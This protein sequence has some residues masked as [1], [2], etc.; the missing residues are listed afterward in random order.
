MFEPLRTLI[1]IFWEF[2]FLDYDYVKSLKNKFI[3]N[4]N[5]V[6]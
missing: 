4:P 3:I 6:Y 1:H 5:L 2:E